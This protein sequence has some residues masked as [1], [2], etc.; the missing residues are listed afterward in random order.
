[1]ITKEDRKIIEAEIAALDKKYDDAHELYGI[2]GSRS[3]ERTMTKYDVL[4]NAL[5]QYLY[6]TADESRER[7]ILRQQDQLRRLQDCVK[8]HVRGMD[9]QTFNALMGILRE[10]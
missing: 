8:A 2:T 7:T 3:T 9:N 1:M 6:H 5:E 4:R 10:F